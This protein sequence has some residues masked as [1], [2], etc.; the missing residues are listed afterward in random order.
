MLPVLITFCS[1][2]IECIFSAQQDF[3]IV[4]IV[5]IVK[6]VNASFGTRIKKMKEICYQNQATEV[7]QGTRRQ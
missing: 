7:K 4:N 3:V 2:T 6:I 1:G 5:N